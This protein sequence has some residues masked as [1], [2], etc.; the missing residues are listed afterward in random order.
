MDFSSTLATI[1]AMNRDDRIR[2]VQAIWD[3]IAAEQAQERV[4]DAQKLELERRLADDQ[5]NPD[6]GIPW[7]EIRVEA[8]ARSGR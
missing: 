6:D 1:R 7:N 4:S 2:L 5:A 8:R 3:E